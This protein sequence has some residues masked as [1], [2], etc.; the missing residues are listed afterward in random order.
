M[1]KKI[2]IGFLVFMI[3]VVALAYTQPQEITVEREIVIAASPQQVFPYLVDFKKFQT[4]SPWAAMDPN[5]EHVYSGTAGEVG[6]SMKW[7]SE[8]T[9]K[10]TQTLVESRPFEYAKTDLHFDGQNPAVAFFK[11]TPEGQGTKV[12]W[13]LE[14]DMGDTPIGRWM[15]RAMDSMVGPDYEKGLA[16]LK[17]TV[18]SA[19]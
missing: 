10:G 13:G 3:A 8:I 4:W 16:T 18:E 5:T 12:I 2:G 19:P 14:A 15:G 11:L 6:S 9:G 7:S 1:L 17:T